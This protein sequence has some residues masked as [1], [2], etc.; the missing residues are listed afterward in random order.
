MFYCK[1]FSFITELPYFKIINTHN[2][3]HTR[4]LSIHTIDIE[5]FKTTEI[6]IWNIK[7]V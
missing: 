5:Q 1:E 3:I 7:M 2:Y 4:T 6:Q